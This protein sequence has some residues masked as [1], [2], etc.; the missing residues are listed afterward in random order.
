[1]EEITL[2]ALSCPFCLRKRK[3]TKKKKKKIHVSFSSSLLACR[4]LFVSLKHLHSY[5]LHLLTYYTPRKEKAKYPGEVTEKIIKLC[6]NS[7]L[8]APPN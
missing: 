2:V 3:R 8:L 7:M 5:K 6:G 1:M 4:P